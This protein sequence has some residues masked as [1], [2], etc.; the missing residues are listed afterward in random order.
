MGITIPTFSNSQYPH[1]TLP[2]KFTTSSKYLSCTL[3]ASNS[4]ID[5]NGNIF[6]NIN[7]NIPR[8]IVLSM[9]GSIKQLA[10]TAHMDIV[11]NVYIVMGSVVSVQLNVVSNVSSTNPLL[12][13][14]TFFHILLNAG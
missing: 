11:P 8:N 5:S 9:T 6:K 2:I 13:L 12:C 3:E 7:P 4:K 14:N 10:I 1:P